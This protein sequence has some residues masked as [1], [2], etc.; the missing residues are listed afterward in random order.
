MSEENV[1]SYVAGYVVKKITEKICISCSLLL[2]S[3]SEIE[4]T[5][6]AFK[7][8]KMKSYNED[9][10]LLTCPSDQAFKIIKELEVELKTIMTSGKT[11]ISG[12]K[13]YILKSFERKMNDQIGDLCRDCYETF[14]SF[15]IKVR[16]VYFYKFQSFGKKS[17]KRSK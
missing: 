7:F 1:S 9:K 4:E 15:Y 14:V 11:P 17:N 6:E 12:L 16:L 5:N 13:K 10:N 2:L 8:L 3:T